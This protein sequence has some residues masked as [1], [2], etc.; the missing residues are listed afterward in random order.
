MDGLAARSGDDKEGKDLCLRGRQGH[1]GH[2]SQ[3]A[4]DLHRSSH[5]FS[6]CDRERVDSS[7]NDSEGICIDVTLEHA[8]VVGK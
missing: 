8:H 7:R 2:L 1:G 5:L 6:T 4:H 3:A